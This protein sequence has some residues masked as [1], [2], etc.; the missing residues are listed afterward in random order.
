MSKF[1]LT[2]LGVAMALGLAGSSFAQVIQNSNLELWLRADQ[3]VTVDGSGTNVT[4]WADQSANGNDARQGTA[5]NQPDLVSN[6]VNGMPALRFDGSFDYLQST[7][8]TLN[9]TSGL[10][11][12]IVGRNNVRKN[13]NGMFRIGSTGSPLNNPNA[14]LYLYWTQGSANSGHLVYGANDPGSL[15]YRQDDNSPPALGNWYLYEV[16]VSSATVL[17]QRINGVVSSVD[18]T[19]GSQLLPLAANYA[20]IGVG[21]SGSPNPPGNGVLN[22]HIAELVVYSAALTP[23]Q[24][25][26]VAYT[27][28]DKY[29]LSIPEPAAGWLILSSGLL[30]LQRRK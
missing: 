22:G 3:G 24:R 18:Q 28:A 15:S 13:Y 30:L 19:F 27:L 8:Q 12:F 16:I 21:Y 11:I 10:S 23:E 20:T 5:V 29:A 1:H 14:D 17:T 4:I 6:A 9:L 2:V 7:N 25:M 26:Q